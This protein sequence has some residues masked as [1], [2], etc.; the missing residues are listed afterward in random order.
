MNMW[1]WIILDQ[2]YCYY[3]MLNLSR[4]EGQTIGNNIKRQTN[5]K[6]ECVSDWLSDLVQDKLVDKRTLLLKTEKASMNRL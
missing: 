2:F 4:K 5:N 6:T 1:D 3:M